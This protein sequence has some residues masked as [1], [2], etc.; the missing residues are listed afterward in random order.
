METGWFVTANDIK[1][2]TETNKRQ[3]EG[4]LPELVRRLILASCKPD[5]LHFPSGDSIAIGGWDGTLEVDE[6][7]EFVPSA[8]L[9]GNL[10]LM[11]VLITSLRVI[12]KNELMIQ[13]I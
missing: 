9:F 5:H 3:A 13:A 10:E 6:G 8:F 7:N 2:W 1:Q 11:E 4:L 12:I